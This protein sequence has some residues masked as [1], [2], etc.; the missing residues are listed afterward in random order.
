[1]SVVYV[2]PAEAMIE[3]LID[4]YLLHGHPLADPD[5]RRMSLLGQSDDKLPVQ[6][7]EGVS[8]QE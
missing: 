2:H 1:M 7:S 6:D 8:V 4:L 3:Q 5:S